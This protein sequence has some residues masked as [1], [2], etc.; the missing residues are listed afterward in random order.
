[1]TLK[2]RDTGTSFLRTITIKTSRHTELKNVTSEIE[3]LVGESGSSAGVC[4][5][6]VPHTTAAI[7]INEGDDPAVARDIE[8]TLDRLIPHHGD[9][10]HAEGNSDSHIKTALIGSSETVWI[11][12]RRLVLGRWQAIF[13]AEFD[14]PRT[15]EL[16]V[17][18]VPDPVA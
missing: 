8:A 5:L 4:H 10:K 14:G 1:M 17:K 15:R 2:A 3:S 13:F 12:N 7:L 16:R 18:I 9:Y 11:E 6:Y